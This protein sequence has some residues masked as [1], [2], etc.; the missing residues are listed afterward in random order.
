[1]GGGLVGQTIRGLLY[2]VGPTNALALAGSGA[3]L[4]AVAMLASYLP[5]RRA[6][7]AN[8]VSSLKTE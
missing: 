7:A 4:G 8:P 3:V 1:M 2:Q 5:V 6:L